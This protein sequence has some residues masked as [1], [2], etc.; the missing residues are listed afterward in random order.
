M[1][2]MARLSGSAVFQALISNTSWVGLVRILASFGS[3]ALAGYTIAIRVVLFA[4]LPAWGLPNAAATLVGQNLGAGRPERA[5]T[6]V[7]LAC[8]YNMVFLSAVGCVFVVFPAPLVSLFTSDPDV[9][10]IAVRGLRIVSIGFPS[11][12]YA[13]ILTQAFNGAGDT[14][15]PTVINIFCF[16]LWEIPLAYGLTRIAGLGPSGVFW[17]IAI[18][19]STMA[20]VSAV[21]FRRGRWKLK[22][23]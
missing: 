8:W 17:S 1:F 3:A 16:W 22:R 23:V 21:L 5:E 6:S 14:V 13:M 12:A 15:T 4:L 11:Y 9:A 10:A 19:Y 7:W 2:N 20:A 18:A